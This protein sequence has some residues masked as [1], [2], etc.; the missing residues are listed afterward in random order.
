LDS[1]TVLV[2][3]TFR[4]IVPSASCL[5]ANSIVLCRTQLAL[6]TKVHAALDMHYI[7]PDMNYILHIKLVWPNS[8]YW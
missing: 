1:R 8:A 4:W 5:L 2:D 3:S 7:G 6:S